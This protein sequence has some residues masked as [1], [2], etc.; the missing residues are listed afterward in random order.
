M[1]PDDQGRPPAAAADRLLSGR[2]WEDFCD[3]LREVGAAVEEMGDGV[4]DTDRAEWYRCVT[5]LLRVAC[6][7]Y[8]ENSEPFR[9]R[10]RVTPWRTSVNVQSPDQDHLLCELTD[11][12]R[13]Y[14]I[15]GH[16][17]TVPY[18]IIATLT[19]PKVAR[20]GATD[21]A[22]T[23]WAGLETFDPSKSNA[24]DTL[25]SDDISFNSDGTFTVHLGGPSPDEG[26][27]WLPLRQEVTGLIVRTVHHRR[28]EEVA[29]T[30][31]LELAEPEAVRP[32]RPE[33]MADGLA[34]AAQMVLGFAN[35]FRQWKHDLEHRPNHLE[36]SR[37]RYLTNGGVADREFAFGVWHKPP[38]Q[39]LLIE[40]SPPECEYWNFQLCNIWQENLDNYE[41]G[42]GYTTKFTARTEPDGA[43]LVVAADEDPGIGGNWLDTF[44]HTSGLMG[45][46]F[47]KTGPPPA[48]RVR[49]V[50]VDA[51]RREG[52]AG[53]EGVPVIVTGNIV[54]D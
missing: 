23:A 27:N 49:L 44:G 19:F 26:E 48:V 6:E 31:R 20:P 12:T 36:F 13:S 2:S 1:D 24:L 17:G 28:N 30:F 15:T 8:L 21:W 53:L 47:V 5:R 14:R 32:P 10:L 7:R 9:P 45:L 40:F 3:I 11:T 25:S 43:V 34:R 51:L 42:Q 18:F 54:S 38:G 35:R 50:D 46:R 33:E 41:D 39:A 22:P 29:P 16:R 37:E 52:R 4:S